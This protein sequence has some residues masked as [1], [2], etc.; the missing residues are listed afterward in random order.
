M[1]ATAFRPDDPNNE[2]LFNFDAGDVVEV[3]AS[4][5]PALNDGVPVNVNTGHFLLHFTRTGR[6]AVPSTDAD[7]SGVPDF[8]EE[9]AE[10]YEEVFKFY[11]DEL[12]FR[13]PLSDENLPGGLNGG[14]GRF[15]VYYVDFAGVGDGAYRSDQCAGTTCIGHMIQENDYAGYGYPSLRQANRI[16]A[17][18]E[19]FHAIQ[20]AYDANQG[21][22]FAEG[23]AVWATEQFD[24]SLRDFEAFIGGFLQNTDRTLDKP[25]PGPVDPFSY[26]SAIFFQF[27][28][29]Y[30][31][32][33]PAF[34]QF[35]AD[36][37]AAPVRTLWETTTDGSYWYDN[38][39]TYLQTTW[40]TSFA[41]VYSQ[42]AVWN[43]YTGAR[44][45]TDLA[46]DAGAGYS[47][48]KLDPATFPFEDNQIRLFPASTKYLSVN[49]NGATSMAVSLV[50]TGL[51]AATDQENIR[52]FAA[53]Q[54]TTARDVT[55]I[56]VPTDGVIDTTGTIQVIVFLVNTTTI[57]NSKTPGLCIQTDLATLAAC[58]EQVTAATAPTDAGTNDAGV[59]EET[60]AGDGD[61]SDAG[62]G[63]D[64]AGSIC[65]GT[66]GDG[67]AAWP[68]WAAVLSVGLL[69]CARS[70][71][72]RN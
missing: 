5:D 1:T 30:L 56:P 8:I 64:G 52:L 62:D 7:N 22:V 29:E 9:S 67:A 71:R 10:I 27:L 23:S 3:Y 43:V 37:K 46:Y 51:D 32:T 33:T 63:S 70:S 20:A 14:D 57:G 18:H 26:G 25:L 16:L 4:I 34:A 48:I 11:R 66:L 47:Q 39:D 49:P 61:L 31:A 59:P 44:T 58:V 38:L 54:K 72:R 40:Q 55:V 24:P 42:F 41:D 45:R 50:G 36:D 17:S 53:L 21:S 6:N 69:T 65:A 68:W 60:D 13:T 12:L 19:F 28:T 2:D 15:D 35:A